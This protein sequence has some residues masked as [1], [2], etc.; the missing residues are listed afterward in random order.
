MPTHHKGPK[1]EIRALNAYIAL[2]RCAETLNARLSAVPKSRGLSI[3]QFGALEALHHLGPLCQTDLGKKLL[4][5]GGNI[6]LVVDNL[7]KRGLA[8]RER[9]GDDRRFILVSLT[10]KGRK[11]IAEIFPAHAREI[12]AELAPLSPAEQEELRRLCKKLGT[13]RQ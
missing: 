9:Q 6:T 12:A 2:A 1:P 11:L 13:A 8:R 3:S 4:K 10:D 7:E 5:S